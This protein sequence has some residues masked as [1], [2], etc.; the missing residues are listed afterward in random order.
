MA[1]SDLP[2]VNM[3]IKVK[4]VNLVFKNCIEPRLL[5][6]LYMLLQ[7]CLLKIRKKVARLSN[8]PGPFCFQTVSSFSVYCV[9]LLLKQIVFLLAGYTFW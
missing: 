9:V 4:I 8:I 3:G 2:E 6:K 7:M 1:E 5:Y